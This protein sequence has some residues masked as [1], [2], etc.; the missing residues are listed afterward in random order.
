MEKTYSRENQVLSIVENSISL[1]ANENILKANKKDIRHDAETLIHDF[2]NAGN[3]EDL[4]NFLTIQ[5]ASMESA[6]VFGATDVY[7]KGSS[8]QKVHTLKKLAASRF[9]ARAFLDIVKTHELKGNAPFKIVAVIPKKDISPIDKLVS[10]SEEIGLDVTAIHA[11]K[12]AFEESQKRTIQIRVEADKRMRDLVKAKEE[13]KAV[14][15][16]TALMAAFMDSD[17]TAQDLADMKKAK[18]E[19]LASQA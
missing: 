16:K 13:Q 9:F 7:V 8:G 6:L 18:K 1:N 14:D 12:T 3:I 15:A 5:F 10:L 17:F 2:V 4:P 19:K 11:I